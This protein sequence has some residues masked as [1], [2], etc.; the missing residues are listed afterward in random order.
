MGTISKPKTFA[1]GATIKA[2]EHND[3]YDTIY[4]EFNGNIENAN[5]KS[6]A[7]IDGSKLNM[8]SP[9]PIGVTTPNSISA[10]N[11]GAT[12][13]ASSSSI[14]TSVSAVNISNDT[15][16]CT[17]ATITNLTVSQNIHKPSLSCFKVILADNQSLT[18]GTPATI[19]PTNV[20]FDLRNEFDTSANAFIAEEAG[21]YYLNAVLFFDVDSDGDGLV[22]SINKNGGSTTI[23]TYRVEA[24]STTLQSSGCTAIADLSANDSITAVALNANNNDTLRTFSNYNYFEGYRIA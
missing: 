19:S 17:Q 23:A 21:K 22:V 1:S 16:S 12:T 9:G 4:N 14:A 3:N 24:S 20:M 8:A 6:S 15:L 11:L 7:A 18:A 10:S 2:D 13:V 5:I